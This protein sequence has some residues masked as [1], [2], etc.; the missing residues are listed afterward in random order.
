MEI[1]HTVKM[2]PLDASLEQN[3]KA[4]SEEG[5]MLVPGIMPIGIYH[6]VRMKG[7]QPDTGHK[8]IAKLAIDETKVKILRNG[9]LIEG[10]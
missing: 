6:V 1:E 5:W 10:T 2:F 7:A 8:P 3:V 4:M 9:Q